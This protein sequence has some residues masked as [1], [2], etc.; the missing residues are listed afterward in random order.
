LQGHHDSYTSSHQ[1]PVG[2]RQPPA[3]FLW[4]CHFGLLEIIF[5][6]AKSRSELSLRTASPFCLLGLPPIWYDT[7][8]PHF[9]LRVYG[10]SGPILR[11][12]CAIS[13]FGPKAARFYL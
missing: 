8:I 7:T 13:D 10:I 1:R 6:A 2:C 9:H 5:G 4:F 3:F 12:F 11:H